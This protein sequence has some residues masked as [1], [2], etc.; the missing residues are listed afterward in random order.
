[1]F[2]LDIRWVATALSYNQ[3]HV[4]IPDMILQIGG[5]FNHHDECGRFMEAKMISKKKNES[6]YLLKE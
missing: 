3:R 5:T 1:M 2:S 6:I 4:F